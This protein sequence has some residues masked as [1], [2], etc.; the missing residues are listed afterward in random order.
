MGPWALA[1]AWPGL[2]PGLL[3]DTVPR[4]WLHDTGTVWNQ[5]NRDYSTIAKDFYRDFQ[6]KKSIQISFILLRASKESIQSSCSIGTTYGNHY[7]TILYDHQKYLFAIIRY[8]CD[9]IPTSSFTVIITQ[10]NISC[11]HPHSV[12]TIKVHSI[13]CIM[14][15]CSNFSN[16]YPNISQRPSAVDA[17][18]ATSLTW[19]IWPPFSHHWRNVEQ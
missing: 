17:F 12:A 11:D 7:P 6:V 18:D 10:T 15:I 8:W 1:R 4:Y 19:R 14:P 2:G 3:Y 16:Y 5:W 13:A 9:E